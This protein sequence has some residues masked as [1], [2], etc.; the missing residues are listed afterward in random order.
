M[1]YNKVLQRYIHGYRGPII[2]SQYKSPQDQ[3]LIAVRPPNVINT[4]LCCLLFR[5]PKGSAAYIEDVLTTIGNLLEHKSGGAISSNAVGQNSIGQPLAA[6]AAVIGTGA[7]NKVLSS[8][9]NGTVAA[10]DYVTV[11][12]NDLA[13]LL[14]QMEDMK[15]WRDQTQDWKGQVEDTLATLSAEVKMLTAMVNDS[16][17]VMAPNNPVV[18]SS[19]PISSKNVYVKITVQGSSEIHEVI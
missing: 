18:S 9:S 2:V 3:A 10:P 1:L 17:R 16:T 15:T 19:I 8:S 5:N 4:F 6:A 7:K 13:A 14:S 11:S 12:Q